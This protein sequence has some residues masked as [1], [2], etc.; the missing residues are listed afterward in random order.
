MC[1]NRVRSANP[2]LVGLAVQGAI[3]FTRGYMVGCPKNVLAH[4][5]YTIMEAFCSI[6]E[7]LLFDY[8]TAF[9]ALWMASLEHLSSNLL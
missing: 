8:G 9:I 3:N 7:V 6:I 5:P 1:L 2:L 4:N